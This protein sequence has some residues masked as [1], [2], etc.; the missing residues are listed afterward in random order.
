MFWWD[1]ASEL[2]I[3]GEP[4]W[5]MRGETLE[6]VASTILYHVTDDRELA[7]RRANDFAK[8]ILAP[9]AGRGASILSSTVFAWLLAS[10][11]SLPPLYPTASSPDARVRCAGCGGVIPLHP[12]HL[13]LVQ[14]FGTRCD[15]CRS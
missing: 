1:G 4:W 3:V 2:R 9:L 5:C 15:G 6:S 12:R 10:R 13:V 7:D 14:T 11:P 8:T